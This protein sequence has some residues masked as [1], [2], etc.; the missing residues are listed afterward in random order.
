MGPLSWLTTLRVMV[1]VLMVVGALGGCD[2]VLGLGGYSDRAAA[3]ADGGADAGASESGATPDGGTG[4]LT[5]L[6]ISTGALSHP[7][8]PTIQTYAVVPSATSLGL[9]FT[10][11]PTAAA[12]S[13]ITVNGSVVASGVASAPIALALLAPTVVSP[14]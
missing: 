13:S 12:G 7:F 4:T 9:M 11:T 14:A 10:V 5:S 1:M 8:D 3:V 6:N 2:T